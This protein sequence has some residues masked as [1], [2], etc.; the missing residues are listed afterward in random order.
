MT[1]IYLKFDL[2]SSTLNNDRN[3]YVDRNF[4]NLERF[5]KFSRILKEKKARK[6]TTK[7]TRGKYL[8]VYSKICDFKFRVFMLK[9]RNKRTFA[10]R[11][12]NRINNSSR[13]MNFIFL[14]YRFLSTYC[15]SR[16]LLFTYFELKITAVCSELRL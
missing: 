16:R 15:C 1:D 6:Y 14:V 2:K 12:Y 13:K 10:S 3:L 4:S 5:K 11:S 7:N 8:R 9:N